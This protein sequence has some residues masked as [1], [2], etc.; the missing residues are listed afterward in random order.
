MPVQQ[1]SQGKWK[2]LHCA[3]S[4]PTG[5][6]SLAA[7]QPTLATSL[8]F[9]SGNK[10]SV[11]LLLQVYAEKE[12]VDLWWPN[13]CG[14]QDIYGFEVYLADNCHNDARSAILGYRELSICHWKQVWVGVRDIKLLRE[15]LRDGAGETFEFHV[16]R[17]PI[18][19]K[20]AVSML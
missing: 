20:G 19:A 9:P 16:N 14:R 7:V 10:S 12:S 15:P 3:M 8:H 13:R 18:F 17:V 5:Q 6:P 1:W 4:R 11:A 2:R